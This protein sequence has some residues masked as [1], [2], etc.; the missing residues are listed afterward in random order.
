MHVRRMVWQKVGEPD[1]TDPLHE[2]RSHLR[3]L[4]GRR[5]LVRWG[6]AM[7][8]VLLVFLGSWVIV[9]GCDY[10]WRFTWHFRLVIL[11]GWLAS[12]TWCLSRWMFPAIRARESLEDVALWVEQKHRI[13]S[14]LIGALQFESQPANP[15]GSSQLSAAVVQQV[16][17]IGPRINVWE[18]FSYG[19]L[20][21][22]FAA[23]LLLMVG[24]TI[25]WATFPVHCRAAWNRFWLGSARYP[26]RTVIT[27]FT[28]NGESIPVR[29]SK[30][31]V[32][33]K[34]PQGTTLKMKIRCVGELPNKGFGR[35]HHHGAQ[36][37]VSFPLEPS[38]HNH[39]EELFAE[40][41]LPASDAVLQI[42]AGDTWIDPVLLEVAALP[43]IDVRWRI[44]PPK[45]SGMTT[46]LESAGTSLRVLEG[47]TLNV[48]IRGTNNNLSRAVLIRNDEKIPLIYS[49]LINAWVF[50]E[51]NPFANVR[52]EEGFE[53]HAV[54]IDG[55][56]VTPPLAGQIHL[57]L[58]RAPRVTSSAVSQRVVPSANPQ[59]IFD[60]DDDFGLK[61]IRHQ[62]EI[63]RVAGDQERHTQEWKEF[64]DDQPK[65]K[66]IHEVFRLDI[67]AFRLKQGDELKLVIE[68]LDDRG[69]LEP[70]VGRS[71]PMIF[72]VTDRN[73]VLAEVNDADRNSLQQLE[74]ILQHGTG[75]K[76]R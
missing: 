2:L 55:I 17:Q 68:A 70:N 33:L 52:H 73:G 16:A 72:K 25:F 41:V 27:E 42:S 60:A 37:D 54:D 18:G 4:Q 28:I 32:V 57:H 63:S 69:D 13:D 31:P 65:P 10:F 40:H 11:M 61:R 19:Q 6:T 34:F 21:R 64:S 75:G 44:T 48:A 74:A 67:A 39:P 3:M 50:S 8:S 29:S 49:K 53:I 15:W 14:D 7:C 1:V 24:M 45:Y 71:D 76:N 56:A 20:P 43:M 22:R 46:T 58:D 36:S 35:L 30:H 47:S 66:E 5:T 62:I 12:A 23:M 51:R 9:G 26:S 59:I 38:N